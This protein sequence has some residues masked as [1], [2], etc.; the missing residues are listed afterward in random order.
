VQEIVSAVA[1]PGMDPRHLEPGLVPVRGALLGAGQP[2]LRQREPGPVLAL[3]PGIGDL[4]PVDR[5]ARD[6]IPAS[7][8]TT[9]W[10]AGSG[11]AAHS[12]SSDTNQR[13][14]GSRLTVTVDGSAPSGSGR[15][16]TT[17]SGPVIFARC[18]WPSR[19]RNADR[20]YSAEARDFFRDL[21]LG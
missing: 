15:D 17:D 18:S 13:P 1:D 10:P 3:V 7:T 20:V 14:A 16:H 6:V 8:P 2:P 4:L 9:E 19:Y 11:P 5:V 12:H 21:N